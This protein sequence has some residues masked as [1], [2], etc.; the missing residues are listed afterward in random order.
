MSES[1]DYLPTPA[2]LYGLSVGQLT[3][4]WQRAVRLWWLLRSL[5]GRE[6]AWQA[7]LPMPFRYADLR[8]HLFASSHS[9]VEAAS[10]ETLRAGCRGSRCI[11]QRS[12]RTLV[13]EPEPTLDWETWLAGMAQHTGLPETVWQDAGEMIPFAVGHRS[14]R[15]DLKALVE[16]G[17]LKIAGRG[18]FGC[19]PAADWPSLPTMAASGPADS[20]GLSPAES[21]ELLSTLEEI[22]FVQPNLSVLL[23]RLW[24][25]ATQSQPGTSWWEREPERR[26][27]IHLDYILSSEMQEQVDTHQAMIEQL[28]RTG[29]GGIIQFDNWLARQ[30]QVA[31][32]TVYPVC[33][34]YARRAKYLSAYGV[35][36]DGKIGWHN[37]R[38]DRI[39]S[40]QI[41]LLPWGDL[42]VPKEL[43]AMRDRGELPTA[44]EVAAAIAEAWGFNFYLPKAWL[45]MRFPPKFARWYVDHTER[46]PTFKR[47]DYEELPKMISR[48]VPAA[49]QAAVLAIVQERSPG[50]TYYAGWVRVGDINVVMRL[51]DWRPNGEVIAPWVLRQQMAAEAKQEM[52]MY[53]KA[54]AR[55]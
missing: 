38:L 55:N 37:Y 39:V 53:Q 41:R 51:R 54:E 49:E 40:E 10:V 17:W 45:L 13:L 20:A 42:E 15:D 1:F 30:E 46:H 18:Q 12:L 2:V 6:A 34:H 31:T 27:F 47:V 23:D 21:W 24:Q 9:P 32:V 19:I 28:W 48:W 5:Y 7:S 4:R 3:S 29:E 8:A 44:A 43:R 36:P 14:I 52:A 50:D 35:D 11:C 26:I 33:F 16:L 22:A 25:Q